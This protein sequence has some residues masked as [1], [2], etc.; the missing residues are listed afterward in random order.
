MCLDSCSPSDKFRT[1][2]GTSMLP[3][4]ADGKIVEIN[5]K[6]RNDDLKIGDVV[7]IISPI[8]GKSEWIR[9]IVGIGP[10][11]ISA[12]NNVLKIGDKAMSLNQIGI[13]GEPSFSEP[14]SELNLS[15]GFV[16]VIGD[17]LRNAVDSRE[18][19]PLPT[20]NIVGVVK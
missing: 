6:F 19:G 7:V 12:N 8:D 20:K 14:I 10:M 16:Y 15:H 11:R 13:K 18:F 3:S 17:N 4:Y 9:R 5:T 2:R 1:V